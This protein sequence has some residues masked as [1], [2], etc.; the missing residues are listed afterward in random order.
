MAGPRRKKART[1]RRMETRNRKS[2]TQEDILVDTSE[3]S[4]QEATPRRL[5][6]RTATT[7]NENTPPTLTQNTASAVEALFLIK[8]EEQHEFTHN[9]ANKAGFQVL[10]DG[11][12]VWGM[13]Q[14]QKE[15]EDSVIEEEQQR[16]TRN[17]TTKTP[18]NPYLI[19]RPFNTTEKRADPPASQPSPLPIQT[20]ITT[21]T[22]SPPTTIVATTTVNLPPPEDEDD[23][24][25]D[26]AKVISSNLV[27]DDCMLFSEEE[28][29]TLGT[30]RGKNSG[31]Y[32][33]R[34]TATEHRLFEII[35]NYGGPHLQ[36]L[37]SMVPAKYCDEREQDYRF[38]NIIGGEKTHD[39][40]TI[41]NKVLTLF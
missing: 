28:R 29:K 34:K 32:E 7:A 41:L 35:S 40:Y 20:N 4:E 13:T 19:R 8:Q 11:T 22:P 1:T 33:Q 14:E 15:A 6:R 27:D 16:I 10:D 5:T 2:S 12:K 26:L 31:A 23:S 24:D 38:Y 9:S 39:K 30:N 36:S 18:V 3:E 25:D 17:A 37:V 21:A